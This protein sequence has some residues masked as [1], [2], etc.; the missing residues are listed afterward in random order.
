V[1]AVLVPR[2]AIVVTLSAP[3]AALVDEIRFRFDPVMAVRIDAHL[4]LVHDVTDPERAPELLRRATDRERF[5][6]RLTRTD[7]WGPS[8]YGAYLHVDD[9]AGAVRDLY[10]AVAPLE[11]PAWARVGYRP[12][13]TLVHG[14][15][16]TEEQAEAAWRELDGFV[17]DWEVGVDAVDVIE[18][19]EPRWRLV[20]RHRLRAPADGAMPGCAP[21]GPPS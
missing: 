1:P 20:E 2:Q 19:I 4:T 3:V 9:P 17:A 8:R 15:T 12:H 11:A 21:A 13:V 5:R 14:R 7:R 6:V 10:E 16:V 18:L